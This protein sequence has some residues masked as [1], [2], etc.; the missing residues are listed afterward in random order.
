MPPDN[1]RIPE[2]SF[3]I[4]PAVFL[5]EAGLTPDTCFLSPVFSLCAML[6][7]LMFRLPHSDFHLDPAIQNIVAT[8]LRDAD[9]IFCN[10]AFHR[11]WTVISDPKT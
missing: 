5:P 9:E 6:S 11:R 8:V 2:V 7:A 3:A 4:R 10:Q 1:I